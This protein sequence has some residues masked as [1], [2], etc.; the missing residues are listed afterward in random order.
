MQAILL[1]TSHQDLKEICDKLENNMFSLSIDEATDKSMDKILNVLVGF[2]DEDA[3][4]VK[5]VVSEVP[6]PL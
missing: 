2:Y 3:G 1:H 5:S 4:S 6:P